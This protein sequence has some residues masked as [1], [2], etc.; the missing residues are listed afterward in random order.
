M[1]RF[2]FVLFLLPLSVQAGLSLE[3]YVGGGLSYF[4]EMRSGF[5]VGSRIGYTNWGLT[6][7]A[8]ISYSQYHPLD[9]GQEVINTICDSN[10][11]KY[12]VAQTELIPCDEGV[13]KNPLSVYNIISAGPSVSFGLPLII[14][15]YAALTWSWADKKINKFQQS[16]F[17]SGPGVKLGVSYLSLPFLQLNLEVQALLLNCGVSDTEC[18]EQDGNRA[19][20]IFIGQA[21]ISIPINTGFL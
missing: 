19:N 4:A 17:L 1:F 10:E 9:I 2:L 20:P 3:P 18:Q 6:L 21:S 8:D 15:A 5:S 16:F 13:Q 11:G 14:D 12:G 7:G